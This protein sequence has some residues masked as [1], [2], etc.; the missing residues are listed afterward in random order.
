MLYRFERGNTRALTFKSSCLNRLVAEISS[1]AVVVVVAVEGRSLLLLSIVTERLVA[2][3]C[4]PLN[5]GDDGRRVDA[6]EV[7]RFERGRSLVERELESLSSSAG[8][9]DEVGVESFECRVV[10]RLILTTSGVDDNDDDDEL[11]F[12][13]W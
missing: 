10:C 6:L 5:A 8:M 11:L 1:V 9:C 7:G 4:L 2:C 13:S 12:T 3:C